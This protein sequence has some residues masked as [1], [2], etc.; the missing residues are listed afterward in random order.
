MSQTV[1]E[2]T[3]LNVVQWKPTG[4][5]PD[6]MPLCVLHESTET[7]PLAW[8][9][10]ALKAAHKPQHQNNITHYFSTSATALTHVMPIRANKSSPSIPLYTFFT[11]APIPSR[12]HAQ[13]DPPNA[14]VQ[15]SPKEN[16]P[17]P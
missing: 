17:N 2:M 14:H 3:M 1:F 9:K 8:K 7:W 5:S 6:L 13:Q 4:N 12:P 11:L 15:K 16:T 10:A